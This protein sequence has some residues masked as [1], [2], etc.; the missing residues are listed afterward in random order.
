MEALFIYL[1]KVNVALALF[2][3]LYVILFRKD[4]FIAL[5]RYF[6][7]SAILFSLLYPLVVVDGLRDISLSL[8][9]SQGTE[10][11]ILIGETQMQVLAEDP[12]A[13]GFSTVNWEKVLMLLLATGSIVL[14][15]RLLW[16]LVS[17]FHIRAIS[18]KRSVYGTEVFHLSGETTPFSFFKWIFINTETHS[19]T[20]LNQILLHEKTHARQWHSIDVI[21]MELLCVAFWWNPVVWLMKREMAINLEYLADN[22][23]LRHGINSREYQYHLLRLTYHETAVQIV[24]NFNV[25]QLKQRIMMMN[26]TKS[27]TRKLAKYL[28]L[29]PFI[30]A[31]VTINSCTSKDKNTDE[32]QSETTEQEA[33]L[34]PETDV[35]TSAEPTG[36]VF[37]IVEEIPLFPGGDAAMMKFFSNNIKYPIEAQ[38]KNIQGRVIC[39]FIV[40]KDGSLSNIKVVRGV[41][42]LLDNEAIR[43]LQTMPNWTPGKQ[44]GEEVRVQFTLPV[45]FRLQGDNAK[46]SNTPPPPPPPA[47]YT[48]SVEELKNTDEVFIVVEDQPE[49]SGGNSAMMKWLSDNIKYP[50]TAIENK[51]QGRV[52]CNFVVE[53]DGTISDVKVVRGV[54]ATLDKE[55]VRVIKSMPKWKP[56]KQRG[57]NVRVRYTLPVVF[58]LQD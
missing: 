52:I 20:E 55:A 4:T 57:Q 27:P 54:D 24:N 53:K 48:K 19:D 34:P 7:L 6:F 17:I 37:D 29:L 51:I 50:V 13:I 49:F 21:L 45:V 10:T 41:D 58:K 30:F 22:S 39:N 28:M 38:E 36:E 15:V 32:N 25:S 14:A 12:S 9:H 26:K 44:N 1:I 42:P 3:A 43:V 47:A 11:E 16:Q 56:G 8:L 23:V 40:E 35:T 33:I 2:Y 46:A 31:L 18:E 5:R